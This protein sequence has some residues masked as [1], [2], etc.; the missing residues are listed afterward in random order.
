MR[1]QPSDSYLPETLIVNRLTYLA[2]TLATDPAFRT[3][4]LN[5]LMYLVTRYADA[6][7]Q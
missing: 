1:D 7:D 3:V 4:V 6:F 5:R 2:G